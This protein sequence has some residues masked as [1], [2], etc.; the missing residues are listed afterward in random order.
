MSGKSGWGSDG[1]GPRPAEQH[2]VAAETGAA[3]RHGR[4]GGIL[5][6]ASPS[7]GKAD[8][9]GLMHI[10]PV[11]TTDCQRSSIEGRYRKVEAAFSLNSGPG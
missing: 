1:D 9:T 6:M 4:S 8:H 2:G 3:I 11:D 5:M 7:P 10:R